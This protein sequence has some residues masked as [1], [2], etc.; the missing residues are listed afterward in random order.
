[1][2]GKQQEYRFRI[3]AYTPATIPMARLAEYMGDLA[4]LLGNK[5][6]VHLVR[7]EE[8]STVLVHI[9]DPEAMP[10]VHERVLAVLTRAAPPEALKAYE[11]INRRLSQDNGS[12][13]LI[14][15]SGQPVVRFLG[16]D[17]PKPIAY[18]PFNQQGSLY[19]VPI[20]IGGESDPV[21]VHLQEDE[22]VIHNCYASRS[23]ARQIAPHIFSSVLRVNGN[24]RWERD[25]EGD[26][27]M[28]RFA[29]ADFE[30]LKDETLS[31]AVARLRSIKSQVTE[32]DDPLS[33]LNRLRNGPRI[34]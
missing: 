8:G 27:E 32:M 6:S 31:Q 28:V 1:M 3:E 11:A 19:G 18:G 16:K 4:A 34:Q 26:W 10:K 23:V 21:P 5:E 20:V 12:G 9:V 22:N 17:L 2:A 25:E 33:E 30:V 24:G 7:L 14:E 29:I 15:P 13:I